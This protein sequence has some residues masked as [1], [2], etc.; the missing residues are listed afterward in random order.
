MTSSPPVSP[1]SV[2]SR[3][4]T[5]SRRAASRPFVGSSATT[6]RAPPARA[7]AMATRCAMPPESSC[8]NRSSAPASPSADRSALARARASPRGRPRT[9]AWVSAT[10]ACARIKGSSDSQGSCGSTPISRPQRLL[11]R[12]GVPASRT[13]RPIVMRPLASSPAGNVPM[14]A[15]AIRLLPDPVSPRM[16]SGSPGSSRRDSGDS[17]TVRPSRTVMSSA[18]RR[19]MARGSRQEG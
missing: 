3:F 16:T 18:V 17:R 12:S 14:S 15:C 13:C 7:A 19:L 11:K 9:S 4:A 1:I 2:S 8:G 6:I 5:S 10:C